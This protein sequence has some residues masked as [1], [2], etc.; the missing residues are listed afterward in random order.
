[1]LLD[2]YSASVNATDKLG[3]TALHRAAYK[4]NLEVVKLL[5]SYSQCDVKAKKHSGKT[6]AD[7]ARDKGHSDIVDYLTSQSPV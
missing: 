1:M 7:I 5:T 2:K 6:A 4:G 3:Y